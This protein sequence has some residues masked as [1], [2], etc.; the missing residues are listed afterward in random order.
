MQRRHTA[1]P[2]RGDQ[3]PS[4]GSA[5]LRAMPPGSGPVSNARPPKP[6]LPSRF[7][8]STSSGKASRLVPARYSAICNL[9]SIPPLRCRSSR[10][11]MTGRPGPPVSTLP[12]KRGAAPGVDTSSNR[13]TD[14]SGAPPPPR[15]A[16]RGTTRLVTRP[17]WRSV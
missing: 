5:R 7:C 3:I 17:V 12:A 1:R 4:S 9:P 6:R 16:P 8:N 14:S 2:P 11:L 13:D 10:P 15:R